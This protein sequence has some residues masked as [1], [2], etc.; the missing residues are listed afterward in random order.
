MKNSVEKIVKDNSVLKNRK[1]RNEFSPK[2]KKTGLISL[3]VKKN[4]GTVLRKY[5]NKSRI[6]FYSNNDNDN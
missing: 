6:G 4:Q 1:K 5:K 2:N 3:Y